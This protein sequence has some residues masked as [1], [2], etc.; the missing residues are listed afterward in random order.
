MNSKK[1]IFLENQKNMIKKI[2]SNSYKYYIN[3]ILIK[4]ILDYCKLG[5]PEK[6]KN[7]IL[8]EDEEANNV[9][10]NYEGEVEKNFITNFFIH[11]RND[12]ALM[13]KIIKEIDIKDYEQLAYFLTHLLFIN[14]TKI[15]CLIYTD[16]A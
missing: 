11:I 9:L 14:L 15:K 6:K 8:L 7:Y 10:H 4:Q 16:S 3:T 2:D 12:N 5:V 1:D 13:L